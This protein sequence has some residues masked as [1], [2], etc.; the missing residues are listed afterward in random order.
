MEE[1]ISKLLGKHTMK[2]YL[3]IKE[4]KILC[5]VAGMQLKDIVFSAVLQPKDKIKMFY[6]YLQCDKLTTH[7]EV[8]IKLA[9]QEGN[10]GDTWQDDQTYAKHFNPEII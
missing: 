9:G 8:E 10:E 1:Q 4:N 2:Y 5:F 3:A 7:M 6:L